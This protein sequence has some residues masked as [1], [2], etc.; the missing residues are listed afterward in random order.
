MKKILLPLLSVLLF[1]LSS[2]NNDDDKKPTDPLLHQWTLVNA[3]GG[4]AGSNY[5]FEEGLIRWKF[6][7]NGTVQITNNNTDDEKADGLDTGNYDYAIK[8]NTSEIEGCSKSM[9]V[10]TYTFYCY[11]IDANGQLILDSSPVDGIKYTF[12]RADLIP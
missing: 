9:D 12:V 2:C 4:F 3:T 5:D 7:S 10:D 11:S 8:D 6:N 1:S